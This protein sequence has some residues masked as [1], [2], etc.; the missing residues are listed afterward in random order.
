MHY[1][2]NAEPGSYLFTGAPAGLVTLGA[3]GGVAYL[4]M[5]DPPYPVD[6]WH[7]PPTTT[8]SSPTASRPWSCSSQSVLDS[9]ASDGST[10]RWARPL[11]ACL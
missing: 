4:V 2:L 10:E 8:T 5:T 1:E 9:G 6:G 3:Y 11:D 7:L